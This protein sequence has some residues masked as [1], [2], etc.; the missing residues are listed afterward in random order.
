[1]VLEAA[2]ANQK[3]Q[4]D[5]QFQKMAQDL[6]CLLMEKEEA[7]AL[8]EVKRLE[9][10]SAAEVAKLEAQGMAEVNKLKKQAEALERAYR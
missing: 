7:E 2:L 9:A 10:D 4:Q 5:E 8:T 6:A 1:M 3:Q